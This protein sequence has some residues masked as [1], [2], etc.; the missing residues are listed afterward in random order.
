MSVKAK[1]VVAMS[2]GV[3]SSVAA[4]LLRDQGYEVV[5][6]FLDTGIESGLLGGET[7]QGPPGTSSA[8][9][10]RDVGERLGIR[11][12]VQDRHVEFERIIRAFS[13]EYAR[14]RTP[15]PCV[16]CNERFKL[17][18]LIESADAVGAE[19]VATGHYA[20]VADRQG[21]PAL[22]RGL[23][24]PKDQSYYLFRIGRERLPRLR[25]PLGEMSKPE[26]REIAGRLE[27]PVVDRPE[28]QDVCFAARMPYAAWVRRY[29]PDAFHPGEVRATDGRVVGEHTG[30]ANFTIGQRKGLGIALGR[31]MYVARID[32]SENT[33]TLGDR[34]ALM[35]GRLVAG[36]VRWLADPPGERFRAEVQVRYRHRAA[37]ATVICLEGEDVEVRFDEPQWAITPGQAAVVYD[38]DVVLGGGWIDAHF[39][40]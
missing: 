40:A 37:P 35:R 32:T 9:H 39:D 12:E 2:G 13:A 26:V 27:L 18:H 4:A 22:L 17:A 38:G 36:G 11:V 29:H 21:P 10:V 23:D 3:D 16:L 24:R 20:R 7:G 30:L 15:N 25:L 14:G 34:D 31:P 19:Y 5:G 33:V 6:L 1:V 28:S 8:D